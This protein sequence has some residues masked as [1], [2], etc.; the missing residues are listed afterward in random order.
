MAKADAA[1][2]DATYDL[3]VMRCEMPLGTDRF[4]P[5]S[6]KLF[7]LRQLLASEQAQEAAAS[8]YLQM[9]GYHANSEP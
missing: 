7:R 4:G 8:D 2:R 6:A 1:C 9:E 5:V 3:H